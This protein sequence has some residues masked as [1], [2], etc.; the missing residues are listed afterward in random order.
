MK[1][2]ERK[3]TYM[4]CMLDCMSMEACLCIGRNDCFSVV[5][6]SKTSRM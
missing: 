2:M 3:G 5:K 6:Q 4:C 1:T